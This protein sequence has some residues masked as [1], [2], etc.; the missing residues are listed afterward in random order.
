MIPAFQEDG[1]LPPGLHLATLQE[2]EARFATTPRRREL[3]GRL[4]RFVEL[5]RHASARRMF[6]NGSYVT[7]KPEPGDVDVVI[8]LSETR[9][10]ELIDREDVHVLELRLMFLTRE[11]REAF[12]VAD[13]K[14]WNDW[15]DFFSSER[16]RGVQKGVVEVMLR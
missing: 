9:Y 6:L 13:E 7:A 3:F 8:W 5:A 4:Q 12:A 1:F 16:K 14:G 2:I 10:S 15:L 11:P